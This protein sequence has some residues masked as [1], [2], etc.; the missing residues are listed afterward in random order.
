MN[1][2]EEITM[3]KQ[4]QMK[5][6]SNEKSNFYNEKL[7]LPNKLEE[8]SA[9]LPKDQKILNDEKY[10]YDTGSSASYNDLDERKEVEI[11]K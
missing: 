8:I 11:F 10:Y 9:L 1:L 5:E 2:E 4:I 6:F 7:S 3:D